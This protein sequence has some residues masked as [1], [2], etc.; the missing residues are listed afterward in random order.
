MTLIEGL[1]ELKAQGIT[2]R[3]AWV[4]VATAELRAAHKAAHKAF[5][6]EYGEKQSA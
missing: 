5:E 1:K 6:R 2:T 4:I 3:E